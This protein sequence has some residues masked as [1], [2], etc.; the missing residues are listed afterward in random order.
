MAK[1]FFAVITI[2]LVTM[3]FSQCASSAKLENQP[4]FN[5]GEVYYKTWVAGVKGGG[6][7]VNLFVPILSKTNSVVFDSL[8]FKNKQVK[9]E[10]SKNALI[11]G[12]FKSDANNK[13]DII[14]SNEPYAE[15]GNKLPVNK[16][17]I[18]FELKDD[19]CI[20][21]YTQNGVIKYFKIEGI[22][23]KESRPFP[24]VK[25]Q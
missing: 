8:Y 22:I 12:R 1:L 17:K 23:K 15:Y 7:G 21:S 19:E 13:N 9:V 24:S 3:S 25:R 20:L 11:I 4:D 18:P 2:T 6:S 14:M 16:I 10:E 5:V